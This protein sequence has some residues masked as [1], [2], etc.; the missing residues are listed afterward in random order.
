VFRPEGSSDAT[1]S[2]WST[3]LAYT[4][5]DPAD[6]HL[7]RIGGLA[8]DGDANHA[9]S[10]FDDDGGTACPS[11]GYGLT[12]PVPGTWRGNV[13]GETPPPANP[14][15][16]WGFPEA[17]VYLG[18]CQGFAGS[19]GD[20]EY[21]EGGN[22]HEDSVW[23]SPRF[24]RYEWQLEQATAGP[25]AGVQVWEVEH[26]VATTTAV[27]S[28]TAGA[29]RIALEIGTGIIWN[30][31]EDFGDDTGTTYQTQLIDQEYRHH[32]EGMATGLYAIRHERPGDADS[33]FYAE[34]RETEGTLSFATPSGGTFHVERTEDY[35]STAPARE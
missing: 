9:W 26:G 8:N 19:P 27:T 2:T 13:D 11:G 5:T 7:R 32:L 3:T 25:W 17:G 24:F 12:D 10:F 20:S 29:G 31:S 21:T 15:Y 34:S 23:A 33:L 4:T 14:T 18:G 6:I 35:A 16:R 1:A 30:G 28:L 22:A